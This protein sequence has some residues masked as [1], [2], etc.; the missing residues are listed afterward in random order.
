M[1]ATFT[2]ISFLLIIPKVLLAQLSP[3]EVADLSVKVPG[4][5]TTE[6]YYGFEEGDELKFNYQDF[7]K[8]SIKQIEIVE[9]PSNVKYSG[10]EVK[11]LTKTIKINKRG[12][13][14]FRFINSALG[15]R[16]GSVKISRVPVNDKALGFNPNINWKEVA[17]TTYAIVKKKELV[18]QDTTYKMVNVRELVN[19]ET[20]VE[21]LFNKKEQ[22]AAQ[23][24][25]GK[26]SESL[27]TITM[28]RNYNTEL[29]SREVVAWAYWIGVGQEGHN[30]FEANKAKYMKALG[31]VANATGNPLIG[32]ALN[33]FAFLPTG[34]AGSNVAYYFFQDQAN[35]EMFWHNH[36]AKGW[37][38]FDQGNGVSGYGRKEAP[39]QG[40]F[41]LGLHNDNVYNDINV[42]VKFVAV[43]QKKTYQT[44]QIKQPIV[45]PRYEEKVYKQPNVSI[46]KVPTHS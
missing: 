26:A 19:T 24:T 4:L 12:I 18:G 16:V 6:L 44:K 29:E 20:L 25:M 23:M 22:V 30:A 46:K 11:E 27:L 35:A 31:G 7:S 41:Y 14:I 36:D 15:Q 43:V 10:Y 1:K 33:Q 37:R 40:T 5:E 8:K 32:L 9:Y 45:T 28:P 21:E 3:V 2:I 17:D 38:F 13:Y 42:D 39:L 34:N